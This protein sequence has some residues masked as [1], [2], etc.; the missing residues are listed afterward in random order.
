MKLIYD[1]G[2]FNIL[3]L[4]CHFSKKKLFD[5]YDYNQLKLIQPKRVLSFG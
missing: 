3:V 1:W 2:K 4:L 5:G